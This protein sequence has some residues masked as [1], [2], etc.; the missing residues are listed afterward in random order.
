V[1]FESEIAIWFGA[2]Y[3][4]GCPVR[5]DDVLVNGDTVHGE[6]VVPGGNGLCHADA[7]PHAYV[8]ALDRGG[9]PGGPFRVQ[10]DADDP[11]QGAPEERTEVDVDLSAAGA[12][13][14]QEEIHADPGL[15]EQE[16]A[17]EDGGTVREGEAAAYRWVVDPDCGLQ[18]LGTFNGTRWRLADETPANAEMEA[19][20]AEGELEVTLYLVDDSTLIASHAVTEL[21]HVPAE[22]GFGC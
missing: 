15:G 20:A 19:L 17:V 6:F 9:L 14:T 1:D 11:P 12:T 8:V 22:D 5:L 7:N 4:S 2:V 21:T 3:G 16:P 10:L 18:V 13:A